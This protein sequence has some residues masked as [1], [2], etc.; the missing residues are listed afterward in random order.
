MAKVIG[1]LTT[2]FIGKEAT[3]G[4]LGSPE[5]AVPVRAIDI[6]DVP[7]YLDNDSGYGVISEHNDSDL[8]TTQGEGGYDGKVFDHEPGGSSGKSLRRLPR[9][10]VQ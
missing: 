3:R 9:G 1:R 5:F 2:I 4:T 7:T 6:D 10:E 8:N